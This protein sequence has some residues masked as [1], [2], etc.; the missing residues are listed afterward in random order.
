MCSIHIC[1][2]NDYFVPNTEPS[3]GKT[4]HRAWQRKSTLLRMHSSFWKCIIHASIFL[5]WPEKNYP[6][7][8]LAVSLLWGYWRKQLGHTPAN[9]RSYVYSSSR[10]QTLV[11]TPEWERW[12]KEWQDTGIM[13]RVKRHHHQRA[14]APAGLA[15]A[16]CLL[17]FQMVVLAVR[18]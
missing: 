12:A 3:T 5:S 10:F 1:E 7:S 13:L 4:Q 17:I 8:W 9:L 2:M 11:Q 15:R 16:P 18:L 6:C 14:A